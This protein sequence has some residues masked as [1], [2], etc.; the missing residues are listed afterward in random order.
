[1]FNSLRPGSG[2]A[3][4]AAATTAAAEP[5]QQAASASAAPAPAAPA[6]QPH[7]PLPPT[8]TATNNL[9]RHDSTPLPHLP[10][11]ARA[12]PSAI[13]RSP[14]TGLPPVLPGQPS[15]TTPTR[16]GS[17]G[18]NGATATATTANGQNNS[19]HN[20]AASSPG[21]GTLGEDDVEPSRERID[22]LYEL[23]E[24]ERLAAAGRQ[25]AGRVLPDLLNVAG[26]LTDGAS[27]MVDDSFLKCFQTNHADPWNWNAYLWPAWAVGVVL[28]YCVLFPLRLALL[29][30]SLAGF[31]AVFFTTKALL[32]E[33]ERKLRV[34][35]RLVRFMC[36]MFVASWTGVVRFHGARPSGGAGRVWVANHTSMIDYIVLSSHSTF[37]VIMQLQPGWVGF[38]MK[39]VLDVLGCVWFNRTD[40][41]DRHVVF[42]RMSE[43]VHDPLTTPLLVFPEGTCVNNEYCVM[44]K[45]GAFE[46]NATVHPVA[47]KYN[48]IFVDAFWNSKRQSFTA[49]L[50]RL[51][52]SWAVVADVWFLE[53]QTRREG[54][55]AD[56]FA[57]RVQ[58]AIAARAGLRVVPWDGYLKYYFLGERHPHLIEKRRKVWA[59]HVSRHLLR[60]NGG[61]SGALEAEAKKDK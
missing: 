24:E 29:L 55:S 28:R 48:K 26:V 14:S 5:Q 8:T 16:A 21:P 49:Y 9:P 52:T 35:R 61:V 31:F 15:L 4:Q 53:P 17:N 44:F 36:G 47:I 46:L 37:A 22:A 23:A 12:N 57:S 60:K 51:M 30:T 45:R 27:A 1:M 50:I 18:S 20:A 38:L 32:P 33:G 43:H 7:P 11:V 13:G 34:Q 41:K 25:A 40:A 10:G 54:E 39:H 59:D 19:N 2:A 6:E 3:K 56:A 58:A 42:S